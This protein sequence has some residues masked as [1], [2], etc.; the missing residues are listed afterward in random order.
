MPSTKSTGNGN[1]HDERLGRLETSVE[2]L[3]ASI[4]DLQAA[5]EGLRTRV[6][7]GR[8]TNWGLVVTVL[9]LTISL[10]MATIRPLDANVDRLDRRQTEISEALVTHDRSGDALRQTVIRDQILLEGLRIDLDRI[11]DFGSPITDRRLSLLE[12]QIGSRK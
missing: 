5:I 2:G 10:Y 12:L 1:S 4:H 3:S 7:Q 9:A 6:T 11:R 8:E